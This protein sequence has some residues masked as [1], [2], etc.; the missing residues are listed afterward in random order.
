MVDTVT[1]T[2]AAKPGILQ[3]IG[4]GKTATDN[5]AGVKVDPK[6]PD[7][8][9]ATGARD[10]ATQLAA[11]TP[12]INQLMQQFAAAKD[13]GALNKAIGAAGALNPAL[14]ALNAATKKDLVAADTTAKVEEVLKKNP[15]LAKL[16]QD[17]E[18]AKKLATESKIP[19]YFQGLSINLADTAIS[20]EERELLLKAEVHGKST[21]RFNLDNVSGR[22]RID[23]ATTEII[24][25]DPLPPVYGS[26]EA[27]TKANAFVKISP[28]NQHGD[29]LLRIGDFAREG[30]GINSVVIPAELA[31]STRLING[32]N[33]IY[34]SELPI[35]SGKLKERTDLSRVLKR[36]YLT[37]MSARF[38]GLEDYARRQTDPKTKKTVEELQAHFAQILAQ[39]KVEEA[40]IGKTKAKPGQLSLNTLPIF[41]SSQIAGKSINLTVAKNDSAS[42]DAFEQSAS[43]AL[44]KQMKA[45]AKKMRA[46]AKYVLYAIDDTQSLVAHPTYRVKSEIKI[47]I[48]KEGTKEPEVLNIAPGAILT[49]ELYSILQAI[50]NGQVETKSKITIQPRL[51]KALE[52]LN[53]YVTENQDLSK[54]SS[55]I[56]VP[57]DSGVHL[58]AVSSANGGILADTFSTSTQADTKSTPTASTVTTTLG[59]DFNGSA[60]SDESANI[61]K[62]LNHEVAKPATKLPEAILDKLGP[63]LRQQ[64][65]EPEGKKIAGFTA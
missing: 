9:T 18:A 22:I 25:P 44:G 59:L 7:T 65:R 1:S 23:Q 15:E 40:V 32:A 13:E 34:V 12:D 8:V 55:I 4:F 43:G 52:N 19:P 26:A 33:A 49:K 60:A 63:L 3:R 45:V 29:L 56:H 51:T 61:A 39:S 50:E 31:A 5:T 27:N 36:E 20:A 62:A 28:I 47:S 37:E 58:I 42:I 14:A 38:T 30:A 11:N 21:L 17:P 16:L 46:G 57:A 54:P 10:K 24:I 48:N 53:T 35:S 41:N 6:Q 2:A 64:N